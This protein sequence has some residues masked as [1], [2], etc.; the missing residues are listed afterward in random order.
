MWKSA[1]RHR[2]T[3]TEWVQ[4]TLSQ[5]GDVFL[6]TNNHSVFCLHKLDLQTK[7]AVLY[8]QKLFSLALTIAHS[9]DLYYNSIV[10]IHQMFIW[11]ILLIC[12]YGDYLYEQGEYDDAVKE[13]VK[14]I[15]VIEPSYV[16]RRFLDAHRLPN[17][18]DYLEALHK[19]GVANK[20]HTTLLLKCYA[21]MHLDSKLRE[22]VHNKDNGMKF[23]ITTAIRVLRECNCIA[24]AKELAYKNQ[25]HDYVNI[26]IHDT[27]EYQEAVDYIHRLPFNDA[28]SL[29]QESGRVLLDYV[30]ESITELMIVMCVGYVPIMDEPPAEVSPVEVT[31]RLS[32]RESVRQSI[33]SRIHLKDSTRLATAAPALLATLGEKVLEPVCGNPSSYI[34]LFA[35]HTDLLLRFLKRVVKREKPCDTST[36]NTLLEMELREEM[37]C[38]TEVGGESEVMKVLMDPNARYD[39]EEALILVQTYNHAV[40]ETYLFKKNGMYSLLLQRYLHNNDSQ[41]AIAL[42]KD[43]GTQ[44]SSLWI[45]LIMILAQQ[46]KVNESFLQEILD[47]VERSQVL[48][49]LYVMQL[50]CQNEN[51]ELGMVRKYILHLLQRQKGIIQAVGELKF[52]HL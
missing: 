19:Q 10:E 21:R 42:C 3:H 32:L 47:Y 9:N 34:P 30:G 29:I 40:G 36:W 23:D 48:P 26:L 27:K 5:W 49:L 31:P 20:D 22:F 13:Y 12:R 38:S 37:N 18:T 4:E 14:T 24:E 52:P 8:K 51:I 44:Q 17:L 6:F 25:H 28:D 7:L 33:H 16:I 35:S 1:I 11:A 39:Q 43:F 15:G 41:A 46:T 45:Q 50:L 2:E